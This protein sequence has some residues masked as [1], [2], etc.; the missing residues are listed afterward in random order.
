[1]FSSEIPSNAALHL[2]NRLADAH[3]KDSQLTLV[4]VKGDAVTVSSQ[5]IYAGVLCPW[6][7][8]FRLLTVLVCSLPASQRRY[9]ECLGWVVRVV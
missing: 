4:I 6:L 8:I 9:D 5:K 2:H 1:M 3:A 7:Q